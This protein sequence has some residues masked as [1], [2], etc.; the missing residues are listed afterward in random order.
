MPCRAVVCGAVLCFE[1]DFV[2]I[3]ALR[4]CGVGICDVYLGCVLHEC[5]CAFVAVCC[6][7]LCCV[8]RD[9]EGGEGLCCVTL[10]CAVV[11]WCCGDLCVRVFW[12]FSV[13]VWRVFFRVV[14][15]CSI[16]GYLFVQFAT[17]LGGEAA[18]L[19]VRSSEGGSGCP[20]LC[21]AVGGCG[22]LSCFVAVR[23]CAMV[24][25]G[26]V[27]MC[28]F[29]FARCVV[30]CWYVVVFF[31]HF[32]VLLWCCAVPSCAVLFLFFYV[33]CIQL[34]PNVVY[35]SIP[36]LHTPPSQQ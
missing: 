21:F 6:A 12:G 20:M 5:Y 32:A 27:L 23:S 13:L 30:L 28:C 3:F 10:C 35:T 11:M 26:V 2:V 24:Y 29:L 16:A 36:I 18:P 31:W 14:R 9:S 7:V 25:C 33:C 17:E 22:G 8:V 15:R 19:V 4:F 1:S 34:H